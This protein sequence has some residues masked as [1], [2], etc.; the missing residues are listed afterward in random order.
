MAFEIKRNDRRPRYRVQLT[1]NGEPVDLT[2][3]TNAYFIMKTGTLTN[4]INRGVMTF[5]DRATGIVEYAWANLDTDTAGSYNAEVEVDW[6]GEPQTFP[7]KGY[8]AI[9]IYEDLG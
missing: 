9:T 6:G 8:F 7:S 3:A 2:G 5:V 1:S 4:K